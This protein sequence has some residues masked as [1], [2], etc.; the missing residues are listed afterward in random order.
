NIQLAIEYLE[1]RI[2]FKEYNSQ[3]HLFSETIAQVR[4][5]EEEL[6]AQKEELK[7]YEKEVKLKKEVFYSTYPKFKNTSIK[8]DMSPTEVIALLFKYSDKYSSFI[9]FQSAMKLYSK[10][11]LLEKLHFVFKK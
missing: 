3:R 8:Y 5:H 10:T 1:G 9:Q 7:A 2:D 6:R 4:E 11:E